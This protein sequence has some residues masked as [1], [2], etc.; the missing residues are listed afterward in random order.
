[1]HNQLQPEGGVT[2]IS[3]ENGERLREAYGLPS[4][5]TIHYDPDGA[6]WYRVVVEYGPA[7]K[8]T[9]VHTF[10][11]FAFGYGGEGPRG[12]AEWARRNQ[13]PLPFKTITQLRN[14]GPAALVF[15]WHRDDVGPAVVFK[16]AEAGAT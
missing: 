13:V 2:K 9:H 10:S 7:G 14:T 3:M 5:V 16:H 1:M 8:P 11:G 6:D 15:M 12:L 4:S